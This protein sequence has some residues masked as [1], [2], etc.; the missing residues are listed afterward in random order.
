MD[1]EGV[2]D[3]TL[4]WF[5]ASFDDPNAV[6]EDWAG[7]QSWVLKD[8]VPGALRWIRRSA[9][10]LRQLKD[11]PR[12]AKICHPC[13]HI[14]VHIRPTH[15]PPHS[16]EDSTELIAARSM[17]IIASEICSHTALCCSGL[18]NVNLLKDPSM[19]SV[20]S[21][22]EDQ[23]F[24]YCRLNI[25]VAEGEFAPSTKLSHL[26]MASRRL[27]ADGVPGAAVDNEYWDEEEW[28]MA[29]RF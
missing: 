26:S 21:T 17:T 16:A 1:K 25:A 8:H 3:W 20:H 12:T 4:S 19:T 27:R 10:K 18:R 11:A 6:F 14:N 29:V 7:K 22:R 5:N 24:V 2:V 13:V 9:T 23:R 15:T 28:A